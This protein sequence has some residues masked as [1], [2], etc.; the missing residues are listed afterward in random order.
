MMK[1]MFLSCTG[2]HDDHQFRRKR[3]KNDLSKTSYT[4]PF[5]RTIRMLSIR[6]LQCYLDLDLFL[7]RV[8]FVVS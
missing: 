4:N 1:Q 8:I 5:Y 7:Y 2:Q 3:E 6:D